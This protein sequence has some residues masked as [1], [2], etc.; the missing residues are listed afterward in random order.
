MTNFEKL[1]SALEGITNINSQSERQTVL[2]AY[3]AAKD[4]AKDFKTVQDNAA[5]LLLADMD[6]RKADSC[7]SGLLKVVRVRGYDRMAFDVKRFAA[8]HPDLYAEYMTKPE[9]R[10][11]SVR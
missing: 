9:R 10:R 5:A 7:E 4:A 6:A 1:K 8:D 2:R 3:L 11:D